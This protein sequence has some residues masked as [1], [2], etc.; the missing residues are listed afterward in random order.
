MAIKK[1][2]ERKVMNKN[3]GFIGTVTLNIKSLDEKEAK[4][5]GNTFMVGK[6]VVGAGKELTQFTV[7]NNKNDVLGN[8]VEALG[9]STV[10]D[11]VMAMVSPQVDE[12]EDKEGKKR[13]TVKLKVVA[14]PKTQ[15]EEGKLVQY[16]ELTFLGHHDESNTVYGKNKD[17]SYLIFV[18]KCT[19]T[20]FDEK[21]S[22]EKSSTEVFDLWAFGDSADKLV[23]EFADIQDGSAVSGVV[24]VEGSRLVIKSMELA[25]IDKDGKAEPETPDTLS[26]EDMFLG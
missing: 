26:V 25:K 24:K 16:N 14:M 7:F 18:V 11:T 2:N 5:T 8:F 23:E 10:E 13:K 22:Q 20:W 21:E 6:A 12:W 15:P 4:S 3:V 19:R 17:G 9:E 1:L